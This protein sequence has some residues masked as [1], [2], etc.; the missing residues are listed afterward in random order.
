MHIFICRRMSIFLIHTLLCVHHKFTRGELVV[1]A[2]SVDHCLEKEFNL[3][4]Y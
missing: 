2:R 1:F 3:L 4:L